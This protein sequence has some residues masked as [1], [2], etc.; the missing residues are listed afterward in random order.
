MDDALILLLENEMAA[1]IAAAQAAIKSLTETATGIITAKNA[2]IA[3]LEAQ[4]AAG[5][6]LQS[7]VDETAQDVA[8]LNALG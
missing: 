8:A 3:E 7:L 2:K 4:L 1:D 5:T 6:D